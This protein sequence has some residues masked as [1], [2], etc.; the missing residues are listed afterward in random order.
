MFKNSL[1]SNKNYKSS[2]ILFQFNKIP[3]KSNK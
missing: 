2:Q 1:Q 3:L